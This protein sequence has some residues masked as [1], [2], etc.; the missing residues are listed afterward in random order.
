MCATAGS[1]ALDLAIDLTLSPKIQWYNM[2][3]G[4]YGPLPSRTVGMVLGRS[5]L[6]S[7]G[8]IVIPGI[9]DDDLKGEITSGIC[10]KRDAT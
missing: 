8:F 6:T 5:G 4:I 10:K 9:I 2:I 3:T 1:P 7:Q